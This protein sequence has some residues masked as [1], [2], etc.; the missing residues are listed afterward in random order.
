MKPLAE[1]ANA[2]DQLALDERVDV[3]V[4][5]SD[6]RR[7]AAAAIENLLQRAAHGRRVG[8]AQHAGALQ[9][10]DVREAPGHIVFEQ[11][12]VEPEGR[13]ELERGGIGG[14]VEATGPEVGSGHGE[15]RYRA[16]GSSTGLVRFDADTT[17]SPQILMKPSAAE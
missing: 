10:L 13:A 17:G 1:I 14:F 12:P 16:A 8:R 9:S 2:L 4:L 11:A 6:E 3:L 7:V 15:G 5:A